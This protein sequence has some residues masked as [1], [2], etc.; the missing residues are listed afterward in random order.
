MIGHSRESDSAQKNRV[1]MADL[2][3][4]VF[5]HHSPGLLIVAATPRK[6]FPFKLDASFAGS[7][8]D[9]PNSFRY[10]LL[11]NSVS[12]NDRN[13]IFLHFTSKEI[14]KSFRRCNGS[15]AG[16]KE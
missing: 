6:L 14:P 2:M 16:E 15:I 10:H 11:T 13:S 7:R 3:E 5:R 12:L 1:M 4:P 9:Y 8:V